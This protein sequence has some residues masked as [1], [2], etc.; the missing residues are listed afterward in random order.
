[1]CVLAFLSF[2]SSSLQSRS[3]GVPK[4][5]WFAVFSL[6]P[7]DAADVVVVSCTHTNAVPHKHTH[8]PHWRHPRPRIL[9]LVWHRP[10]TIQPL[11]LS[12][13]TMAQIQTVRG[14]ERER[15]YTHTGRQSLCSSEKLHSTLCNHNLIHLTCAT[16]LRHMGKPR[17]FVVLFLSPL[18]RRVPK[19]AL[20]IS[21]G[22]FGL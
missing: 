16:Y 17:A 20:H 19:I 4:T 21:S 14:R 3:S 13:Y 22:K 12:L 5:L 10:P 9:S 18:W 2:P 7:A 1:M 8:T 11:A 15:R 6:C